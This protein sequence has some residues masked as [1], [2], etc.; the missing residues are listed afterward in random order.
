MGPSLYY[1]SGR[2]LSLVA[3]LARHG[4]YAE[5]LIELYD[6]VKENPVV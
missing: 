1:L 4:W 5:L 3:R 2:F 6:D